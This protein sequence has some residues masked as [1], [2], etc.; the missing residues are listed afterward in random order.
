[1]A[2]LTKFGGPTEAKQDA[3]NTSLGSIDTK[4]TDNATSSK[5]DTGNSSLSNIDGKVSTES[6]QDDIITQQTST[7]TKIDTLNSTD[8]STSAKQDTIIGHVDGIEDLLTTIDADTGSI[9][10]KVSTEAKQDTQI[11]NQTTLNTRVGDLTESAPASDTASSGLN[12]RLQRIAQRLTSI[13]TGL[14]DGTQQSKLKGDTDGTLI[15]NQGSR[16]EVVSR[17]DLSGSTTIVSATATTTF[18]LYPTTAGNIISEFTLVNLSGNRDIWFSV[19]GGTNYIE[20][21]SDGIWSEQRLRG[22]ITQIS[23]RSSAQTADFKLLL[24]RE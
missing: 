6:K 21:P 5:Q 16:L 23:L 9:N 19:D 8:F 24:L 1:M 11:T 20:V 4:L 2:N 13:F 17:P 3:A 15:G 14:S 7:N 22:S 18:T 10:S 12:G